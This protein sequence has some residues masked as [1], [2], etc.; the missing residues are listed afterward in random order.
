MVRAA[1]YQGNVERARLADE[2][3]DLGEFLASLNMEATVQ[4]FDEPGMKRIVQLINK[5]NQFNLTTIRYTEA[6]VR[7]LCADPDVAT[8]QMRLVDRFGDNGM[9]SVAICRRQGS[10]WLI[11]SW[12]MSCRVFKRQAEIALFEVMLA[13]AEKIGIAELTGRYIPT[14]R[15][16]IVAEL[17]RDLGFDLT[18]KEADGMTEWRFVVGS[19]RRQRCDSI[20]VT[21]R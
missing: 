2:L 11:D 9:I 14:R 5:T 8:F 4:A 20:K 10:A 12:L 17:Y 21:V 3:P 7:R 19:P 1:Q 16:A 6:E 15:N 18:S 13:Q